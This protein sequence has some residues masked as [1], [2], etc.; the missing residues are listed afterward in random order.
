MSK[1]ASLVTFAALL[2]GG[3]VITDNGDD[4]AGDTGASSSP[5]TN[6]SATN[7]TASATNATASATDS[8]SGTDDSS[9]GS[10]APAETGA[11]SSS[12]DASTGGG[13]ACGWGVTG[14]KMV[15][16]GYICGGDGED[17]SGLMPIGCPEGIE[18]V[19]GGDCGG[20]MG[21][22]GV[23]CC[24]ANGDVWYCADDGG[25]AVLFT[26]PC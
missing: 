16:M 4:D 11:D 5:T 6:S 12:G 24:D 2:F 13:G 20:N 25:G 15:P 1:S 9:S 8:A 3:C 23:G 19:E 22:T 18:L 14:E 26:S 7:A 10:T 17:P 21:I